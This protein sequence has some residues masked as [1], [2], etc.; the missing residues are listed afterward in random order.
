[1][2][3]AER[4]LATRPF[5]LNLL[6]NLHDILLDSGRGRD[7]ARGQFRRIQNWIGKQGTPIEQAQFV[8]PPP[9]LVPEYLDN[10]EKYY[11]LNRP[12]PLVQLAIV[13]AQ[14]EIIH[15]FLDGNGRLGRIVIPLF[16]YEKKLLSRPMFYLSGWLEQRR[17]DYAS[18][19]RDLGRTDGA[20][21]C[22]IEFF[23][24][25][26][27]EQARQNADTARAVMD[28]Y[29]NLK[30][31]MIDLTHSQFAVPM[32]D[33]IFERPVFQ[34]TH[35]KFGSA[36]PSRPAI[37]GLLRTLRDAKILKTIREGSGR[38]ATVYALPALVNLCEGKK[39]L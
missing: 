35:F 5:T 15:P 28:L 33:Q 4:A 22:W 20:W 38:R 12:D 21:N 2:R 17:E 23:L 19:L 6:L 3:E 10:W 13:H 37:A 1:M 36:A 29:E 26:V 25:G 24:T 31:Q 7:K 34:S 16:L 30:T 27:E 14:F 11:H 39:V 9:S 32:L 8:P 18:N